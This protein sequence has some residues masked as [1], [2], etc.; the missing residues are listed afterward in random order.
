MAFWHFC[1]SCPQFITLFKKTNPL[2]MLSSDESDDSRL[3][4][5]V[6]IWRRQQR[7]KN[8]VFWKVRRRCYKCDYVTRWV[9]KNTKIGQ[10]SSTE[11]RLLTEIKWNLSKCSLNF[12]II[13]QLPV[14]MDAVRSLDLC[15][16]LKTTWGIDLFS[17]TSPAFKIKSIQN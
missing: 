1:S 12:K 11:I 4:D 17:S 13:L 10:E 8:T 9:F 7:W 6:W 14:H 2:K 15:F 3:I 5:L 16:P